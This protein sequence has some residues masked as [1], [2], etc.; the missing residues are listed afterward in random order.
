MRPHM[1]S[2]NSRLSLRIE[3]RFDVPPETVFDV[4]TDPAQMRVWWGDDTE[5]DIDLRVGGPWTITRREGGEEYVATGSYL[6]VERPSRLK[7]T[8]AMPQF[9]PNSDTITIRIEEAGGGSFVTF[10]HAG[11][12][13]AAELKDLPPGETSA[14]E[15]GWQQGFDLMAAAWSKRI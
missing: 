13:I 3:R 1:A 9:S 2:G 11:D 14:T 7:Y 10:E 6:E 8:F 15:A 12:D 4:L 5:F